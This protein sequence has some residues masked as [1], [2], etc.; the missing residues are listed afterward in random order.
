MN[1]RAGLQVQP[2]PGGIL[3]HAGVEAQ[4]DC[5]M[6]CTASHDPEGDSITNNSPSISV[7]CLF[8]SGTEQNRAD[9]ETL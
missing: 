5:S 6:A 2:P 8:R 1:L 7:H 4:T 9:E 3:S